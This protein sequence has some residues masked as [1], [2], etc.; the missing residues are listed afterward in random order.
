MSIAPYPDSSNGEI[1]ELLAGFNH[2][3]GSAARF[4]EW[5]D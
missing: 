1:G 2:G 4:R 3:A 5:K